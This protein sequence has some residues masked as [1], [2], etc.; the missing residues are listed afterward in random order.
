M[1]EEII[2]ASGIIFKRNEKAPDF[3]IGGLSIKAAEF[4]QWMRDNITKGEEWLNLDIKQSKNG[5]YY[6]ALNTWKPS[7]GNQTSGNGYGH[8]QDNPQQSGGNAGGY[9]KPQA[10]PSYDDPNDP[11]FQGAKNKK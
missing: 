9:Q 7:G 3:V 6:I 1:N 11:P 4:V 10:R 8:A 5:K 2:F